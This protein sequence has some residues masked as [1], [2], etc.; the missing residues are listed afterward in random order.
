V[1]DAYGQ[2]APKRGPRWVWDNPVPAEVDEDAILARL[3]ALNGER[4]GLT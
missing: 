4:A 3:L 1:V 2:Q